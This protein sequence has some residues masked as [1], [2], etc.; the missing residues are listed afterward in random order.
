MTN[1]QTNIDKLRVASHK[2]IQNIISEE[3]LDWLSNK[4]VK[5]ESSKRTNILFLTWILLFFVSKNIVIGWLL[6]VK[7]LQTL[8]SMGQF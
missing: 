5:T 8:K 7:I 4:K 1:G 3:K 6:H 2:I